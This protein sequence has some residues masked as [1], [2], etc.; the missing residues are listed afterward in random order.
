M[1][2]KLSAKREDMK[3]AMEVA[4]SEDDIVAELAEKNGPKIADID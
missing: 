3:E 4:D 1:S 2:R